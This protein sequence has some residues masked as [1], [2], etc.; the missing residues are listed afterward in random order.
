MTKK[1]SSQFSG[2]KILTVFLSVSSALVII[3]ALL[4]YG[5]A[6]SA[7]SRLGIPHAMIFNSTSDLLT[8]GGWG[9]IEMVS[10]IT[11]LEEWSF[12]VSLW[13]H[14]WLMTKDALI[15][16]TLVTLALVL[17][18]A[19]VARRFTN[20]RQRIA[21]E[22]TRLRTF[23]DN[24]RRFINATAIV[25]GPIIAVL[26]GWPLLSIAALFV[27]AFLGLVLS[28][29]PI[30]GLLAGTQHIDNW[31][32][33][34]EI[35]ASLKTRL[36][37]KKAPQPAKDEKTK[38]ASCVAIK[39]ADGQEHRGRVAFATSNAIVLYDPQAGT[40]QRISTDGANI[41]AISAL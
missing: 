32:I 37:E 1:V 28:A 7:D 20:E 11:K 39:K 34:P 13:M 29:I 22:R 8:L 30:I 3:L 26:I 5:V 21:T 18:I 10:H 40:I 17:G 14:F 38:V 33:G 9:V 36:Q 4:G 15:I 12:Y 6:L 25:V 35:C 2:T 16:V 41:E 24:H 31:V 23:F 19:W 27:I